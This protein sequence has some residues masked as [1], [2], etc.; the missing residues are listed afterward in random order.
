MTDKNIE[1]IRI[2]PNT[3]GIIQETTTFSLVYE[4]VESVTTIKF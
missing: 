3:Q 1:K 2:I 4:V